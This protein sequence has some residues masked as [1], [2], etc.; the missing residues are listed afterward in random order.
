M[1]EKCSVK[2]YWLVVVFEL[3]ER[4]EEGFP[5]LNLD[6]NFYAFVYTFKLCAI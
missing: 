2:F 1:H 5:L 6:L 4:S 3:L